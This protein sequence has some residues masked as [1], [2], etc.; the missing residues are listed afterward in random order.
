M[1][2]PL[3][4]LAV[5]VLIDALGGGIGVVLYL[6]V[7]ERSEAEGIILGARIHHQREEATCGFNYGVVRT[8]NR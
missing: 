2:F 4:H 1:G 8:H 6:A 7:G 5:F 3:A